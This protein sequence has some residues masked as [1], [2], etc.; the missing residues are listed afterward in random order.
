[1]AYKSVQQTAT[2]LEAIAVFYADIE[3]LAEEARG[4]VDGATGKPQEST[5]RI[6]TMTATADVLEALNPDEA[7]TLELPSITISVLVN[8][9][10][11]R[12]PSRAIR[13]DNACAYAQAGIDA[14]R[15]YCDKQDTDQTPPN[16]EA[17]TAT[18]ERLGKLYELRLWCDD[19]ESDIL[20][21]QECE[22]P[23][24]IG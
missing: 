14:I 6:H 20:D 4:V 24:M 17:E 18:K 16:A 2:P 12:E 13:R 3:S 9:N 22:F 7:P 23:G 21:V 11:R 5:E 15:E 8:T 1:M 19:V 10:K